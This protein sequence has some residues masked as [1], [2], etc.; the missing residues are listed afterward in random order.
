M[1]PGFNPDGAFQARVS[2]PP[3]YR[4]PE[5]VA[6]FSDRVSERIAASPGVKE[7][8]VISVAPLSG[9]LAT[10]PFSIDGQSAGDRDRPSAN[11]R[12]ITPG[13]LSTVRTR[14]V[15]GRAFSENDDVNTPRVALVSA[16]LADKF[17][18]GNAVGQRIQISDNNSGARPVE[19]VGVV[20]NVRQAALDL[21]APFDVYIPL[22]RVHPDGVA[23]LRNN[24]FWMVRTESDPAAS[25]ATFLAHLRA[26]DPDA[27]VSDMG[28]MRQFLF[29]LG[30]LGAF[31]LTAALLAVIGLYG[32]VSY[33]VSQRAPEIGL[34]MA[35]GATQGDVRRMILRQAATLGIAGAALGLLLAAAARS[36]FSG[37]SIDPVL[38]AAA[39]GVLIAIELL[40]AWLPARRAARIE[41]TLALRAD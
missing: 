9:L 34:R 16:A 40:A 7:L 20:E 31:A 12:V 29:S 8:G 33:V 2:I 21:P 25:R 10:V 18:S 38:A 27:A 26:V 24:Q 30:L 1:H 4:T 23:Q 17:L 15:L 35:M 39:A 22:R 13:Y 6:R 37:V 32:L 36:L 28:T 5:E 19:I 14:L 11:I 41:P 3:T